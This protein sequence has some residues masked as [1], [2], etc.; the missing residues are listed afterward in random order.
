MI[1]YPE[2][3]NSNNDDDDNNCNAYF[4]WY[5]KKMLI[6]PTYCFSQTTSSSFRRLRENHFQGKLFWKAHQGL[7]NCIRI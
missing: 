2:L 3:D 4:N 1:E 6:I 7:G 5:F